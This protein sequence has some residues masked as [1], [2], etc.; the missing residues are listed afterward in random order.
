MQITLWVTQVEQKVMCISFF[1]LVR[2]NCT[3]W[4]FTTSTSNRW[5]VYSIRAFD[6]SLSSSKKRWQSSSFS[7]RNQTADQR[8]LACNS[9]DSQTSCPESWSVRPEEISRHLEKVENCQ[10]VWIMHLPSSIALFTVNFSQ[11]HY[12]LIQRGNCKM[13]GNWLIY[14]LKGTLGFELCGTH[15]LTFFSCGIS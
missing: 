4:C 8:F 10:K 3:L 11:L 13:A 14:I 12:H 5:Y 7:Q 15:Q 6:Y 9:V 2:F 1:T